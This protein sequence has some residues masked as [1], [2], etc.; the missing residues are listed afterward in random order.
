[1][2]ICKSTS[3]IRHAVAHPQNRRY[4]FQTFEI[5]LFLYNS[6]T[7]VPTAI[8]VDGHLHVDKW[9]NVVNFTTEYHCLL[10]FLQNLQN[11]TRLWVKITLCYVHLG[12]WNGVWP[13][14]LAPSCLP[15]LYRHNRC[16]K[17]VFLSMTSGPFTTRDPA[18]WW[19]S[20]L[21]SDMVNDAVIIS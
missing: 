18:A 15:S 12:R 5:S 19:L 9:T 20:H 16:N 2:Y 4:P 14:I 11:Y 8:H 1:M 21:Y 6:K 13:I 3:D 17:T 10:F 7:V